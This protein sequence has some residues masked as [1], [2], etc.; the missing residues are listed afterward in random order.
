MRFVLTQQLSG[1]ASAGVSIVITSL[2]LQG[3]QGPSGSGSGG[4]GPTLSSATPQRVGQSGS[5]GSTGEAADAGHVHQA[6]DVT[7]RSAASA[8]TGAEVV[9]V[10]QGGL[11]RT[12]VAE[13][14]ATDTSVDVDISA[15]GTIS[16]TAAQVQYGHINLTGTLSGDAVVKFPNSVTRALRMTRSTS[17][18][19]LVR[20]EGYSAGFAY[21]LPGQHRTLYQDA[22]YTLR[23][24]GLRVLV[25]SALVTLAGDTTAGSPIDHTLCKLPAGT[26]IK[27]NRVR[28]TTAIAGSTSQI[29]MGY[30]GTYDRLLKLSAISSLGTLLGNDT[31]D[32][33][34]DW[35]AT[36]LG[37]HLTSAETL[38]LRHALTGADC[39]AGVVR[40]TVIAEYEGE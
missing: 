8:L 4:S 16:L 34:T 24:E 36:K 26:T 40:V 14:R 39:S 17:G 2:S 21:L 1:L 19:A 20:V 15:G 7:A 18:T 33:G 32:L 10:D 11:T 23:G 3:P 25:Y 37:V 27:S 6:E 28:V 38:K 35:T 9:A 22:S 30:T 29:S 31:G 12:T 5:A 13:V